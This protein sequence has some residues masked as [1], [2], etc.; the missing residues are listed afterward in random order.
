MGFSIFQ[1]LVSG[2]IY[3]AIFMI[4]ALIA[5]S[6]ASQG[7]SYAGW[8]IGGSFFT[9]IPVLGGIQGYLRT[10]D[11]NKLI[12]LPSAVIFYI[13]I[14]VLFI[15]WCAKQYRTAIDCKNKEATDTTSTNIESL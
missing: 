11:A 6:K 5:R 12:N 4:F 14:L 13:I 7:K 9:I 1:F 2:V 3:N 10:H 15:I 8:L